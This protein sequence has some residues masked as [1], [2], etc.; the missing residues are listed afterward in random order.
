[1]TNPDNKK[2]LRRQ[3][4]ADRTYKKPQ[5]SEEQKFISKSSKQHKRKIEDIRGD[6]LW[7][8]WENE[9]H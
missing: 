5:L 8:D 4:L 2:D 6:E 7:E 3:K 9:V 1:M